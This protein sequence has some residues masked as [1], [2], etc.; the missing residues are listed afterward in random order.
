MTAQA[1]DNVA[2]ALARS[3][4]GPEVLVG[5]GR[6]PLAEAAA[7]VLIR[8]VVDQHVALPD[9]FELTFLDVSMDVLDAAGLAL[10]TPVAVRGAALGGDSA[11]PLVEGEVTAIEGSYAD[12]EPL[13]IVRGCTLDHRLQRVRR[14]RTFV[15]MTD[16]DVARRLAG[17]AGI[18]IGTVDATSV[19]HPQVNQ[20]HQTDWQLLRERAEELGY[21]VGVADGKFYF[22][23][24]TAAGSGAAIPATAGENLLAFRP[25]LSSAGL[26]PEVEVRAWDAANAQAKSVRKP[27][28]ATAVSLAGADAAT[29]A[30]LFAG[31][32]PAAPAAP[33]AGGD[34]GPPP[35]PHAHVVFD[36]AVTVEGSTTQALTNAAE[37]LAEQAASGFAEAEGD[38]LGD[39]RVVAGA[40]LDIDGVP[41]QF[42][43]RWT[44]SRARHS[45]DHN[46][47]DGYRT[48]F[49]VSGRQDRSLL[50]LA[51]GGVGGNNRGPTRIEGVAMGVVTA[52][53]DPLGLARVKVALPWLSPDY[54]T[55]WAPVAQLAAGKKT[56][57]L[58]LP[59]PG[60]QVLVAFEFGDQRRP[61]VLGA[62][63]NK[64]TGAG[65]MIEPG[66]SAPGNA[67]VKGGHPAAVI[68]RGFVS[69]SGNRLVF[70]DDGPPGGGTPTAS[71]VILATASDK[72][73]MTLDSVAGKLTLSCKPGSPP[74]ALT[75]EC[76]GNVEIKAGPTGTLTIDG[77]T[78]LTLKG[79]TVS[80]EGT[81]P[82]AVKGKPIQLN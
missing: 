71:Q 5:S 78:S 75:I 52:I 32:S 20:D 74:G 65:G 81:G 67:A 29:V 50:A 12:A 28:S 60:D 62:V 59:E 35:S 76:D 38:L 82:V 15:S 19:T 13:T 21:E 66:G 30:K 25:R 2:L 77:G 51:G 7:K 14:A 24:A 6:A 18:P 36:R 40:V 68:R 10:G 54:E 46:V 23:R 22:R 63:V 79:T 17:D 9:T 26:V 61:Y 44:V 58:F 16:S 70:H 41:T 73:G 55:F 42:A 69:P 56:G 8:V 64:R 37:A 1:E 43:G 47:G 80:I 33:A 11:D 49:S 34:L 27:I 72:V 45:F 53:D 4:T 57:A 3:A 39:A 48:W 31:R